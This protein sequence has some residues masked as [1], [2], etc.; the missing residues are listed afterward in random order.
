MLEQIKLDLLANKEKKEK[1]KA[2][3]D[4]A[5]SLYDEAKKQMEA[6]EK[7]IIKIQKIEQEVLEEEERLKATQETLLNYESKGL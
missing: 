5:F 3:I 1:I 4:Q 7:E 2:M 6:A